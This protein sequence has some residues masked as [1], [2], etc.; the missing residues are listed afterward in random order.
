M[1][2]LEA[3]HHLGGRA[4]QIGSR[5]VKPR[6][7]FAQFLL[8]AHPPGG[9]AGAV[10]QD[11]CL[12]KYEARLL[13]PAFQIQ[14]MLT[15]LLDLSTQHFGLCQQLAVG[16]PDLV[17][18]RPA[19]R[20]RRRPRRRRRRDARAAL[21]DQGLRRRQVA[22]VLGVAQPTRQTGV[23]VQAERVDVV[24]A[25]VAASAL[26]RQRGQPAAQQDHLVGVVVA[27]AL[28]VLGQ[29]RPRQH[30]EPTLI[31]RNH[32]RRGRDGFIECSSG[33][34]VGLAQPGV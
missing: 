9:Q 18:A 28:L 10:D 29:Q 15:L 5:L 2:L 7:G 19:R 22:L 11:E 27:A 26:A 23:A 1:L 12:A 8:G 31:H 17:R 33:I 25:R 3:L 34:D 13:R 20:R 24:V 6:L 14:R 32:K 21:V 30:G 4:R 16:N